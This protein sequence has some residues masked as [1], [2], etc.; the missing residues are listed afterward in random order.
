MKFGIHTLQRPKYYPV[1]LQRI[2]TSTRVFWSFYTNDLNF[3]ELLICIFFFIC[4]KLVSSS[5]GPM[6]ACTY[7]PFKADPALFGIRAKFLL[8][9]V[10]TLLW[11]SAESWWPMLNCPLKL[12]Y[13]LK[14]LRTTRRM[15]VNSSQVDG[16]ES[17]LDAMQATL[18][19]I[20]AVVLKKGEPGKE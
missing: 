11:Q 13:I 20:A 18:D 16:L 14:R 19:I 3:L 12:L 1:K 15:W 17:W 7:C 6:L 5:S 9:L 10:H 2:L 8:S 4:Y